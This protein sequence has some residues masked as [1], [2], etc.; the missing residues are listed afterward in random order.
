MWEFYTPKIQILELFPFTD[1]GWKQG[2]KME[3]RLIYPDL[4]N[5]LCLN[6][7]CGCT[8]SLASAQKGGL[9]TGKLNAD[10][11]KMA[12]MG[13][14]YGPIYGPL[15]Y[16]QLLRSGRWAEIQ[17]LG[18]KVAG[19]IAV[20]TGQLESLRTPEHQANAGRT[21]GKTTQAQKWIDPEHPELGVTTASGI[22]KKQ[23]ARGLPSDLKNRVRVK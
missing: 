15:C 6:E 13:K 20:E 18:G 21:G 17:K 4:N 14:K 9:I 23:R 3:K 12:E 2:I 7:G 19:Q 8:P 22:V 11:G 16:Q 5:L 10:S 1:E